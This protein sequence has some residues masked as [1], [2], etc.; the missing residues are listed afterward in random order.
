MVFAQF[1]QVF[2][3]YWTYVGQTHCY[4][5]PAPLVTSCSV[6]AGE[7][8]LNF[9][10]KLMGLWGLKKPICVFQ[11]KKRIGQ[12]ILISPTPITVPVVKCTQMLEQ[13]EMTP[14]FKICRQRFPPPTQLA[15]PPSQAGVWMHC[16]RCFDP[17]STLKTF[18]FVTTW[19]LLW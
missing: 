19:L 6:L 5:R 15:K 1:Q 18:Y 17:A 11:R 14:H 8:S 12:G 10:N 9:R 2:F 7:V 3:H 4:F 13:G 16:G